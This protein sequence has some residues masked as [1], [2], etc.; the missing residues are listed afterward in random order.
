MVNIEIKYSLFSQA[1]AMLKVT[2]S[3]S[4]LNFVNGKD[5]KPAQLQRMHPL[6]IGALIP[7]VSALPHMPILTSHI[8]TNLFQCPCLHQFL[9]L[10]YK[11][12]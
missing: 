7:W 12:F 10:E 5:H 9:P 4:F 3:S 11:I 2:G 1:T 8:L 6:A